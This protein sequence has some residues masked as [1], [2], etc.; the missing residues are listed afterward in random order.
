MMTDDTINFF[1]KQN[2]LKSPEI[3]EKEE[4]QNERP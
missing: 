3:R 4:T 1:R 2:V